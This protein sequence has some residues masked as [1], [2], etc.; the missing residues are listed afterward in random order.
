MQEVKVSPDASI[1]FC[2]ACAPATGYTKKLYKVY[3]AEMQAF[4]AQ[5]GK[6]FQAAPPHNPAC[7]RIFK[8][9]GPA[10][11]FL[12]NGAEYFIDKKTPEPLQLVAQAATD[13]SKI[14]WYIN[15]RFYKASHRGEKQ[16]F[17]PEEGPVKITCSDD[18][19]RS[20]TIMIRVKYV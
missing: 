8:G 9:D 2:E 11:A 5:Q 12:Q 18:K 15:D 19:G 7:E 3:D 1:S 20:R 6:P 16:F 13:V 10:I 14:Y 17:V 4:L